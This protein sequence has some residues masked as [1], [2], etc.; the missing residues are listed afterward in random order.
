VIEILATIP[1][2]LFVKSTGGKV[3]GLLK[4]FRLLRL[5]RILSFTKIGASMKAGF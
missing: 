3:A 5:G 4:M 1:F 2:E